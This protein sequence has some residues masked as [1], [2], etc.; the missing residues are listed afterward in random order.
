MGGACSTHWKPRNANKIF[1]GNFKGRDCLGVIGA[2]GKI[3]LIVLCV[4]TVWGCGV[5]SSGSGLVAERYEHVSEALV[6][7]ISWSAKKLC[8]SKVGLRS[9]FSLVVSHPKFS[10]VFV[11]RPR[12]RTDGRYSLCCRYSLFSL[13]EFFF[14]I[15]AKKMLWREIFL[16]K[17]C[18]ALI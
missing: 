12:G 13:R 4:A 14:R 9:D 1:V 5:E 18:P 15:Y 11:G 17:S 16:T 2:G 8:G 6:L 3:I 7:L 10:Y